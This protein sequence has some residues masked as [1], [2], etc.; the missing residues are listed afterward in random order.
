MAGMQHADH[1]LEVRKA[2]Q[3][4]LISFA[5]PCEIAPLRMVGQAINADAKAAGCRLE[6]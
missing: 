5:V 3:H 1:A 6:I 2:Q 4:I